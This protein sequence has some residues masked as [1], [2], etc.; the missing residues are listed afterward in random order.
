M[1]HPKVITVTG[2]MCN[3]GL[4]SEDENGAPGYV[5][6]ETTWL[7]SAKEL[8]ETLQGIC[9][10]FRGGPM[11]RHGLVGGRAEVI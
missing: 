10:N 3:W 5:R 9:S 2:P 7:T 11:R 1:I 4:M 8:G 6:K